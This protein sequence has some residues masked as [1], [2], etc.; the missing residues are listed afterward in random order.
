MPCHATAPSSNRRRSSSAFSAM[1]F[2]A[3][4][5][6]QHHSQ[7]VQREWAPLTIHSPYR[8][9]ASSSWTRR[10]PRRLAS[11]AG[12]IRSPGGCTKD[13]LCLCVC[14]HTTSHVEVVYAP[15]LHHGPMASYSRQKTWLYPFFPPS[16]VSIMTRTSSYVE[17]EISPQMS[18]AYRQT[19]DSATKDPNS[20]K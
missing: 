8:A 10:T 14:L 7:S 11:N 4:R 17:G 12:K 13:D 6:P 1:A 9:K 3:V 19:K 5:Q 2:G 16:K 20:N 15:L 18:S